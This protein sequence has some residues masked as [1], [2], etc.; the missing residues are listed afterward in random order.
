MNL[1]DSI[2]VQSAQAYINRFENSFEEYVNQLAGI[3]AS[4]GSVAAKP[5]VQALVNAYHEMGKEIGGCTP[6]F[7][8]LMMFIKITGASLERSE[9]NENLN[10][11]A[12][13]MGSQNRE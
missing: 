7:N 4:A 9:E 13:P 6:H 10:I 12:T 8:T 1:P 2:R 11:L 3:I 5:A